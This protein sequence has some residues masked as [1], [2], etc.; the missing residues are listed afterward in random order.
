MVVPGIRYSAVDRLS[1]VTTQAAVVQHIA[2][3][4]A[5]LHITPRQSQQWDQFAQVV[6][7]DAKALDDLYWQRASQLGS[8]SAVQNLRSWERIEEARLQQMQ[9]LLP[10]FQ[11]LYDALSDQQKVEADRYFQHRSARAGPHH[12]P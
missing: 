1:G 7:D 12:R 10:A 3:L 2:E 4:R 11:T 9:N 8:M 5:R 6:R